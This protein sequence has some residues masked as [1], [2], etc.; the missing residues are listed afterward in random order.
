MNYLPKIA[1]AL[2]AAGAAFLTAVV[3]YKWNVHPAVL[4]AVVTIMAGVGVWAIPNKGV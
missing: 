3:T 2:V 1:K 4:V